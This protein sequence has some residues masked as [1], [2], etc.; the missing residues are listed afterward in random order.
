MKIIL[1][2]SSKWR[3]EIASK[4]L[5]QEVELRIPDIDEKEIALNSKVTNPQ[6][7]V[8]VIAKA[9]LEKIMKENFNEKV[10][11]M[12]FD[13]VIVTDNIILEKP[14]DQKHMIEM[15]KTWCLKDKITSIYTA[16]CMGTNFPLKT[17]FSVEKADV[18]LLRDLTIEEFNNYISH[19][20][21]L[22]SSGAMVVEYLIDYNCVKIDGDINVIF[23]L[24]I[25]K[26]K[27]NFEIL[28]Q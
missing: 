5:G 7:H 3:R 6:D 1:G 17:V 11:F 13:T 14:N 9:K 10:I 24:P 27:E 23:G 22:V 2:S 8:L 21:C 12:C 15:L 4:E 20:D 19:E 28:K 26:V 18:T 25:Q 16:V